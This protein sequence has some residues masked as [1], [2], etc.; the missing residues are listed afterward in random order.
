MP[1]PMGLDGACAIA[2]GGRKGF[3]LL[4]PHDYSSSRGDF[5]V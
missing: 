2:V 3:A 4:A 5:G 1:M